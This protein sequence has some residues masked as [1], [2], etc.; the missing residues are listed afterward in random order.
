MLVIAACAYIGARDEA[1][2]QAQRLDEFAPGF[3]PS[4][5]NGDLA[6]YQKPEDNELLLQGLRE[7]GL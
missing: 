1:A 4:L 5:L 3:I 2:K 6:L 7:A